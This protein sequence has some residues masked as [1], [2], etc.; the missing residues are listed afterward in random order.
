MTNWLKT[1]RAKMIFLWIAGMAVL[2]ALLGQRVVELPAVLG[3]GSSS[4]P[5]AIFLPLP[6]VIALAHG[7]S[8]RARAVEAACHRSIGRWDAALVAGTVM[9]SALALGAAAV[10]TDGMPA[11]AVRNLML[12]SG[13]AAVLTALHSAE[14]GAGAIALVVVLTNSIGPSVR[15]SGHLRVMQA[16]ADDLWSW[17]LA[18]AALLAAI[19]LLVRDPLPTRHVGR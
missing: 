11:L 18:S 12:L 10:A 7:L 1:R 15:G 3:G 6:V 8:S 5:W 4:T 13:T 19:A 17:L 14:A 9:L 2:S 16:P